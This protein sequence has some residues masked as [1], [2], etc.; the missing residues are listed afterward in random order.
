[1][2]RQANGRTDAENVSLQNALLCLDCEAISATAGEEC[3][4]CGA[5][6]LVNMARMLGGSLSAERAANFSNRENVV[7]FDLE[8]TVNLE[9]VHAG[10][11]N[12]AVDG[13]V[14]VLGPNLAHGHARCHINV[15]PVIVTRVKYAKEAA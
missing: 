3:P 6:S 1:M 8:I 13:I 15:E 9:H 4:V 14:R 11:L 2:S 5:R 10:A 12:A 7:L